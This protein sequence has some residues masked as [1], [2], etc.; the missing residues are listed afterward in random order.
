MP[1]LISSATL[2]NPPTVI[3]P[4]A[5]RI[6]IGL[7][8]Q[9]AVLSPCCN[10]GYAG[11][12]LERAPGANVCFVR[13]RRRNRLNGPSSAAPRFGSTHPHSET[14]DIERLVRLI[15]LG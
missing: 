14:F 10:V 9:D 11:F 2:A 3:V 1:P 4:V 15:A 12:N 8:A 6:D 7:I 13:V 5:A